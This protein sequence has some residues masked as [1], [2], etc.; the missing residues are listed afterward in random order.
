MEMLKENDKLIIGII[1]LI[2]SITGVLASLILTI[3]YLNYLE[4]PQQKLFCAINSTFNCTSVMLSPEAKI[5]GFPN[6][7][8]GLIGYSMFIT[9]GLFLIFRKNKKINNL[10]DIIYFL[11]SFLAFIFSYWLIYV[12]V[13]L[14]KSLCIYCIL[15][16]ISST[17]IFFS[18]LYVMLFNKKNKL[19]QLKVSKK[20]YFLALLLWYICVISVTLIEKLN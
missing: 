11:G 1:T 9:Y 20:T 18:M 3:E 7:L 16:C 5:L 8:L 19:I 10:I 6:S 12:S 14:I 4:H 17:N 2:F 15:S 13:F